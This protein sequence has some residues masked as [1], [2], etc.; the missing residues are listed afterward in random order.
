MTDNRKPYEPPLVRRVRLEVNASV[1]AV[2][3]QSPTNIPRIGIAAC[4]VTHCY[5]AQ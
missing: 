4:T 2:C 1:L 3:N 5:T